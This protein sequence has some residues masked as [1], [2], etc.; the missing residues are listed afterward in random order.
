[1]YML[2]VVAAFIERDDHIL[3]ARRSTGDPNVLGKW[4]FPGGKVEPGETEA[5]AIERE[6]FEEFGVS[7]QSEKYLTNSVFEYPNRTVDIHLYQCRYISGEFQLHDHSES[8]WVSKEELLQY[9]LAPADIPLA[10]YVLEDSHSLQISD[11]VVGNK[12][13][14]KQIATA[15]KCSSMGGMRRS[16]KTNSLV[17]IAKHNNPLY[18]DQW[19]EDGILNYTGMGTVGDQTLEGNQN[20][21]LATSKESGIHV[22]LFESYQDNQYYFDG[23]VELVGDVY[24]TNEL[25]QNQNMRTV[26]KF[27]LR[28][29][30]PN[31]KLLIDIQDVKNS[32]K[33]KR[34]SIR[35]FSQKE[36]K[37][38]IKSIVSSGSSR[39]VK[40]IYRERNSMISEYTKKRANG[41]CDLC[42]KPAPFKDKNGNPYL[43]EH[44]VVTLASGGPDKIYNTVAIC[45]N[46]HRRIHVINR[47]SDIDKL[48]K[49]ILK[50]LLDDHDI[51]NIENFKKLF[52]K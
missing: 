29:K 40:A 51:E 39:E 52:S 6:I 36:M 24:T 9:D 26:F 10:K 2:C 41:V 27:P 13:N 14:N 22:Y 32:E 17:L 38:K 16:K 43:E 23:E 48:Q 50:Y 47:K 19:T 25:D 28:L 49:V 1:M 15:F 45:P 35:K 20:I 46:C 18:D 33:E 31:S 11:L 37:E 8:R 30:N 21:T 7:V 12:Y 44:H 42:G 4:E 5:H 34:K 3:I